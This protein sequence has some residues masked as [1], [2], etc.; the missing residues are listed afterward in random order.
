MSDDWGNK[1]FQDIKRRSDLVGAPSEPTCHVLTC[2]T[3]DIDRLVRL[4]D[5]MP[6]C[7]ISCD[8]YLMVGVD[9]YNQALKLAAKIRA[10]SC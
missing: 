4:I 8:G 7:K 5:E 10:D 2:S 3:A 6:T 9:E 1:F